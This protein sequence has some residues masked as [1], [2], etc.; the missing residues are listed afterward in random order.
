M[1]DSVVS[2]NLFLD[3]RVAAGISRTAKIFVRPFV[4]PSVRLSFVIK[5]VFTSPPKPLNGL[6]SYFQGMFPQTPS[7]AY[8]II[9]PIYLTVCL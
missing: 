1:I 5:L 9:I 7:C 6:S 4:R 3:P 8:S 2:Q